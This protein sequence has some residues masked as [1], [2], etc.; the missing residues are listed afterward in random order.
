MKVSKKRITGKAPADNKKNG[1][2]LANKD[3]PANKKMALAKKKIARKQSAKKTA[4]SLGNSANTGKIDRKKRKGGITRSRI[5][6]SAEQ[7]FMLN[8]YDKARFEDIA[9][10]LDLVPS[11]VVYHFP[12]KRTLYFAVLENVFS[13]LFGELRRALAGS[14]TLQERFENMVVRAVECC[15]HRPAMAFFILREAGSIDKDVR[16]KM[17]QIAAPFLELLQMVYEEGARTN[18]IDTSSINPIHFLS[19]FAGTVCF[20][21]STLPG[22]TEN[23]P[24]NHRTKVQTDLL[25]QMII[26]ATDSFISFVKE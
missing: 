13:D 17:R 26:Q 14:G 9:R 19:F 15:T 11:A 4:K 1:K 12:D 6:I 21:V 7:Q 16:A 3:K 8:G 10:E 20:Y 25:A 5:L 18:A 22:L 2:A 23:L 24:D